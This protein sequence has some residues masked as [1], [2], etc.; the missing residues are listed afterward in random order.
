[1]PNSLGTGAEFYTV[2]H[3]ASLACEV[4][5]LVVSSE[6]GRSSPAGPG[7][8]SC[9]FSYEEAK[10]GRLPEHRGWGQAITQENL[11]PILKKF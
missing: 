8:D 3:T 4:T 6:E 7:G 9:G 10:V 5:A 1:M 11:S 2:C